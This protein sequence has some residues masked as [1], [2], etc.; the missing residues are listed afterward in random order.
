MKRPVRPIVTVTAMMVLALSAA[1]LAGCGSGGAGSGTSKPAAAS[2]DPATYPVTEDGTTMSAKP[3]RI[4]SMSPT[5]TDML[6]TIGAGSQVIDVDKN[7][8]YF[9]ANRPAA[10]PPADIDAYQPSAETIAAK[11]PDL[12]V[13][14]DD[15]NKI[16]EALTKI[17]IPVYVAPAATTIDDTYHQLTALGALT[18]H[19]NGARSAVA[20]EKTAIADALAKLTPRSKPLTF[21]YELDQ[22]YYSATSRTFIGSLF[23]MVRM[24]N[25]ADAGNANNPY[26]QLSA[27]VIIHD[28]PDV[29]FLADTQCCHQSAATVAKR[30]GWSTVTA[31][32]TNQVVGVADDVASQ[33]GTRVPALVRTIV[34]ESNGAPAS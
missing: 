32:K 13:I 20:T 9:G 26:P 19:V 23:A 28:D 30:A 24:T 11:N 31:V 12:V 4:I 18:G 8:D 34:T 10:T 33:W 5:A 29:I 27:E 1:G 17:N 2:S 21:Y 22:T 14:S 6:F 7:S 16:K 15:T 25:I 3:S